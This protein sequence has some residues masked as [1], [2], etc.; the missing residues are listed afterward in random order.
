MILCTFMHTFIYIFTNFFPVKQNRKYNIQNLNLTSSS[1]IWLEIFYNEESS[2][3][4]TIQPSE[5]VFGGV[6]ERQLR[7]LSVHCELDYKSKNITGAVNFLCAEVDQ[8]CF[9]VHA[10]HFVKVTR[11]A[12]A[13]GRKIPPTLRKLAFNFRHY[14]SVM[15]ARCLNYANN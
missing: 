8:T 10:K 9:K 13:M 7:K 15:D 3:L 1:I 4:C 5:V 14:I 11:I 12:E 6:P 2:L